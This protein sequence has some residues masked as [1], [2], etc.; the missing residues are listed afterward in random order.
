[1][2]DQT[3]AKLKG[4]N[5]RSKDICSRHSL[6]N[7]IYCTSKQCGKF[8]LFHVVGETMVEGY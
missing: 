5:Q 1:M 8:L 3:T 7:Y 4:F 6:H 2:I